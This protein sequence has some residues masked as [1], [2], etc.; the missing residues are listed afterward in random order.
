MNTG[1]KLSLWISSMEPQRSRTDPWSLARCGKTFHTHLWS[2][3]FTLSILYFSEW[4]KKTFT[5]SHRLKLKY[6]RLVV[7]SSAPLAVSWVRWSTWAPRDQCSAL[8]LALMPLLLRWRSML[9]YKNPWSKK[10][11]FALSIWYFC[12]ICTDNQAQISY[13]FYFFRH[14]LKVVVEGMYDVKLYPEDGETT[15][16][17]NIKRGIISALAVPLLEED[18]N[19][20]MVQYF[21]NQQNAFNFCKF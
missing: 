8:Q 1:M 13:F 19:K 10:N 17:L 21:N 5:F 12:R 15:T 20:N 4:D 14:P 11:S 7:S 16:I 18:K 2:S 9:L 3:D 6:L